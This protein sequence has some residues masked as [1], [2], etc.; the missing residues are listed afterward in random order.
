VAEAS[1]ELER[2]E[3]SDL[4][5][6]QASSQQLSSVQAIAPNRLNAS[7][8]RKVLVAAGR[9][10]ANKG[11]VSQ[12]MRP[13]FA[14]PLHAATRTL[15]AREASNRLGAIPLTSD[16]P[17]PIPLSL[18]S[19][20][21]PLLLSPSLY[22]RRKT[23]TSGINTAPLRRESSLLPSAEVRGD[24]AKSLM[25]LPPEDASHSLRITPAQLTSPHM[26][27]PPA[28]ARSNPAKLLAEV[29]KSTSESE[30]PGST[31]AE[32][33][34][35]LARAEAHLN[36]VKLLTEP[37]E[38]ASH[39]LGT[40]SPL[41][42]TPAEASSRRIPLE[43]REDATPSLR[44]V[45]A[46]EIQAD[47]DSIIRLLRDILKLLTELRENNPP[48]DRSLSFIHSGHEQSLGAEQHLTDVGATYQVVTQTTA[49]QDMAPVEELARIADIWVLGVLYVLPPTCIISLISALPN[50]KLPVFGTSLIALCGF[51]CVVV[52][53]SF[54]Q[55]RMEISSIMMMHATY[56][57]GLI[58]YAIIV[59]GSSSSWLGAY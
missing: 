19:I 46:P 12:A 36:T 57:C 59:Y 41:V 35:P 48:A 39:L 29:N 8:A 10:L 44:A 33:S 52:R 23:I 49:N 54:I 7:R 5:H 21:Q 9:G 2:D 24:T 11:V 38:D 55:Q 26:P 51:S 47:A 53:T 25:E 50:Y 18:S 4:V 32:M 14:R 58:M 27:L 22:E 3:L 17:L 45:L 40:A 15:R 42:S 28:E 6:P 31:P 37:C 20:Q 13:L 16:A 1:F 30:L 56:F 43:S 34:S